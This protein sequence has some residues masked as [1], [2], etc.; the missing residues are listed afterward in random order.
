MS[1]TP[2]FAFRLGPKINGTLTVG[3]S[4]HAQ[5]SNNFVD[6]E[7]IRYGRQQMLQTALKIEFSVYFAIL[8]FLQINGK[9]TVN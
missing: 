4:G 6:N 1:L 7:A 3:C 2:E 5:V 9:L 8:Q